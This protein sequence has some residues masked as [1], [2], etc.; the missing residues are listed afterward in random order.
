MWLERNRQA[1]QAE[2]ASAV[3]H[4]LNQLLMSQM[5]AVEVADRDDGRFGRRGHSISRGRRS[6]ASGSAAGGGSRQ[7]RMP[8]AAMSSSPTE[9][10]RENVPTRVR[11]SAAR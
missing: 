3:D 8:R 10:S 6:V 4:L 2:S 11:V 9:A 7:S 1:A 5:H